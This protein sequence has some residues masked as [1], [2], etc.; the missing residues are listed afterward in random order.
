MRRAVADFAPTSYRRCGAT[1]DEISLDGRVVR[2]TFSTCCVARGRLWFAV[3]VPSVG[4]K[5]DRSE[6]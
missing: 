5:G 6:E 1:H 2:S 4:D 3:Q